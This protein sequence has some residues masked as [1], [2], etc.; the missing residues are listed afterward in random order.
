MVVA[1]QPEAAEAGVQVLMEGGNAVDAAVTDAFT[2]CV[3]D[4][5]MAGIAGYG[6]MQVAMPARGVH[7]GQQVLR[8]ALSYAFAAPHGVNRNDEVSKG[9]ADPQRDGVALLVP[10]LG[11]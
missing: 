11:R 10:Q 9:D 5:L 1:A 4:P 3:V 8:S 6:T 2:Q 7:T